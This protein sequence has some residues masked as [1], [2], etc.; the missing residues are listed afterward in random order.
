MLDNYFAGHAIQFNNFNFFSFFFYLFHYLHDWKWASIFI[1]YWINLGRSFTIRKNFCLD[2]VIDDK[3]KY[4]SRDC[5]IYFSI[6]MSILSFGCPAQ[7]LLEFLSAG[8]VIPGMWNADIFWRLGGVAFSASAEAVVKR[9]PKYQQPRAA[10]HTWPVYPFAVDGWSGRRRCR[11]RQ[12]GWELNATDLW[13]QISIRMRFMAG[14][15][16]GDTD[17]NQ[18]SKTQDKTTVYHFHMVVNYLEKW[19]GSQE[20]ATAS[21]LKYSICLWA[22][23]LIVLPL[24]RFRVTVQWLPCNSLHL[25]EVTQADVIGEVCH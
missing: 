4:V 21:V 12:Q 13:R 25:L 2:K 3:C 19:D 11:T 17:E 10:A 14:L 20:K 6:N 22:T 16:D 24:V 5:V 1:F 15:A 9:R 23:C 18:P 8:P 7:C